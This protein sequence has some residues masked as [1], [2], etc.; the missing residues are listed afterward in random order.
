MYTKDISSSYEAD[1]ENEWLL[2]NGIGGYANS[3]IVGAN[4][5]KYHGLLVA[6]VNSNLER[7]MTL[8]KVNEYIEAGGKSYSISTN[9]CRDYV[10]NGFVFQTSFERKFLPEFLYKIGGVEIRKTLAMKHGENKLC[11]RYDIANSNDYDITFSMVPFV[12]YRSFHAVSN[13]REYNKKYEN[14]ILELETDEKYKLY[15]KVTNSEYNNFV[16]TFY[17]GMYYRQEEKRG[18][19]CIENQYMPGEFKTVV[20][21]ESVSTVYLVAELNNV[22]TITNKDEGLI[23][24]G[25][26]VRL[27]KVCKIAGAKTD[28]ER[29]LAIAA[30]QFIISKGEYK[31][32]VAGYP[33]FSDWGR[34]TFISLEGL[35]LKT[36]RFLDAKL[37]LKYFANNIRRGLV[38]NYIESNNGGS[39]NT[40]DA[41]LWYIDAIYKYFRYTNDYETTRELFP[42][43]LE[44]IYSYMVGTDFNIYMDKDG[45]ISAGNPE[46]NLTWM[47]AK[48]GDY[49]VTPRYGK[50]V[51]I[52]ALWYNSL[53]ICE[54][55]NNKLIE[56]YVDTQEGNLT[57]KEIIN[58]VYEINN[59]TAN[60]SQYDIEATR[61]LFLADKVSE[62][63]DKLNIVFDGTLCKKVKE[64]FKKFYSD[65]GL[66]DTIEP[67]NEEIRPN[68]LLAISLPFP[69]VTGDKAVE[70]FKLIKEQLY[71]N[72]GL[73]TLAPSSPN[74]EARYEGDPEKRDKSYHQG[75]VWTWL[76][77]E[78]ENAYES[79]YRKKFLIDNIQDILNDGIIGSCA[80]IYDAEEPRYANG[81]LAQ[82]WS[83]AALIDI[84]K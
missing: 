64:S 75:T 39:Y 79:I 15:I 43:M 21:R 23:I 59:E 63:Y 16:N 2:T 69:V 37:I 28:L 50:A 51:E 41:S 71:T 40:C 6:S 47:D 1:I 65:D 38:P 55:I 62:F 19:D 54:E 52:S 36:N 10:E 84:L 48:V 72:K 9:E 76:L 33:W 31:S 14:G 60:Q 11:I 18:F 58:L 4:T 42:N 13:A 73:R 45:L 61:N 25:E 49:I 70:V 8:S 17:V 29:E 56:H 5:R 7:V 34:D 66:F 22:C 3:T 30:D 32:I 67:Y 77:G 26:E 35:T 44:I 20:Y 82:A 46:T 68:Q 24:R 83:V 12:N 27:E 53:K 81:A 57:S 78:Y 80:E 74:Y